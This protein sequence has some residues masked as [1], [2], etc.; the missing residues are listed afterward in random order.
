MSIGDS[1]AAL[2]DRN[3]FIK[4]KWIENFSPSNT[5]AHKNRILKSIIIMSI[6]IKE[7][8]TYEI[9]WMAARL[10]KLVRSFMTE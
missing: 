9:A 10:R 6:I 3:N 4:W 2:H 7:N 1:I 8:N 5:L